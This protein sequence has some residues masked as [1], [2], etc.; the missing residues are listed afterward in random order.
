MSSCPPVGVRAN[1]TVLQSGD[2][3]VEISLPP[4]DSERDLR[5]RVRQR[6]LVEIGIARHDVVAALAHREPLL[7]GVVADDVD[8][9]DDARATPRLA[10]RGARHLIDVA[11]AAEVERQLVERQARAL[12]VVRALIEQRLGP[13]R[14]RGRRALHPVEVLVRVRVD[15]AEV[16]LGQR[17]VRRAVIFSERRIA[18]AGDQLR[19]SPRAEHRGR[20]GR[21]CVVVRWTGESAVVASVVAPPTV[22]SRVA[23]DEQQAREDQT[24]AHGD[25]DTYISPTGVVWISQALALHA[26]ANARRNLKAFGVV[27]GLLPVSVRKEDPCV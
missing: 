24:T 26:P 23:R 2:S 22:Q 1:I 18:R 19:R 10:D 9:R 15:D 4:V 7:V 11:V 21:G 17:L 3:H 6:A 14:I 8:A 12:V 27:P 5:R 13:P 20:V 16:E 25:D